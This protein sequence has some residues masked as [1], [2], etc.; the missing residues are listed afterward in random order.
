MM[1]PPKTTQ[2]KRLAEEIKRLSRW[3]DELNEHITTLEM[4]LALQINER[5]HRQNGEQQI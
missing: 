3:R 2:E 4:R 1:S 5:E